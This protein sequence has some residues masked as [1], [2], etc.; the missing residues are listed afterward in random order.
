MM[1]TSCELLTKSYHIQQVTIKS[2]VISSISDNSQKKNCIMI[3]EIP[4]IRRDFLFPNICTF[5]VTE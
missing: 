3:E 4:L 1:T 2:L 5:L